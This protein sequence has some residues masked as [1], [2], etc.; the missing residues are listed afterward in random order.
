MSTQLADSQLLK[1]LEVSK[2]RAIELVRPVL[3]EADAGLPDQE[4]L[5]RFALICFS[6]LIEPGDRV[7][8]EFCRQFGDQGALEKIANWV[9][10]QKITSIE[11]FGANTA[12]RQSDLEAAID[13]WRPRFSLQK[14]RASLEWL[15]RLD[16]EIICES[17]SAWPK[18]LNSLEFHSP[19]ILYSIGNKSIDLDFRG[20]AL[21]GS[22]AISPYGRWVT[23]E[24]SE[25]L[26]DSGRPVISGGAFGVDAIA[27][28]SALSADGS[29]VAVMAGGLDQFYPAGNI[30]LIEQIGERGLVLA[31]VPPG[32]SPTKWRFL[33]R[34][35]LIA[36]MSRATVVVE[37]GFRSGSINTANHAVALGREVGA[38]PGSIDSSTSAGCHELIRSGKASLVASPNHLLDMLESSIKLD[39]FEPRL[40]GDQTRVLDAIGG[41]AAS[42]ESIVKRAGLSFSELRMTLAQLELEGQVVRK[43]LKWARTSRNL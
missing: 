41:T 16:C 33:Q 3:R 11:E 21:V 30:Q 8:K 20:V 26:V 27:H 34:N 38:V 28:Q 22:R 36:A 6:N 12:L 35:R 17:D 31:E 14:F 18:G 10:N 23:K 43:N 5:N 19:I 15:G 42:E 4:L 24:F 37:A 7:A 25:A 29:T 2:N 32:F 40:T 39:V 13:R 9:I 1:L